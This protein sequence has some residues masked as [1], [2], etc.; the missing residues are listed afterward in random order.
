MT[1]VTGIRNQQRHLKINKDDYLLH[2]EKQTKQNRICAFA[3]IQGIFYSDGPEGRIQS[4]TG[5]KKF[6]HTN[7]PSKAGRETTRVVG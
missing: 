5:M 4:V 7:Y 1:K 2:T 6:Q 3:S